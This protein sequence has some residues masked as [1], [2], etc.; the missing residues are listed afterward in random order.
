MVAAGWDRTAGLFEPEEFRDGEH[1][2]AAG[3][4][5]SVADAAGEQLA[6]WAAAFGGETLAA[7]RTF[8]DPGGGAG[9]AG[10]QRGQRCHDGV[11]LAYRHGPGPVVG[12]VTVTVVRSGTAGQLRPGFRGR[13]TGS[14]HG[15]RGGADPQCLTARLSPSPPQP[16]AL[17]RGVTPALRHPASAAAPRC[18]PAG[19]DAS[20]APR[21]ARRPTAIAGPPPDPPRHRCPR[22]R[23]AL[24]APPPGST[25][26]LAAANVS[27]PNAAAQTA[28]CSPAASAT[29]EAVPAAGR[30]SP[31][32]NYS[33]SNRPAELSHPAATIVTERSLRP[34][35]LHRRLDATI[36][37][38]FWLAEEPIRTVGGWLDMSERWPVVELAEPLTPALRQV[39][40]TEQ[41]D[42]SQNVTYVLADDDVQPDTVTVHGM[43]RNGPRRMTLIDAST[44]GRQ[45]VLGGSVGDPGMER[46]QADYAVL[47]GHIAGRGV[48]FTHARVQLQHLDVWAQLPGIEMQVATDGS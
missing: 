16:P 37:G 6:V 3:T 42:G 25:N 28:S 2:P 19:P 35:H 26:V 48:R 41:R 13:V 11:T 1:L 32:R 27:P 22:C 44:A 31:S 29:E 24:P 5:S 17:A 18:A 36:S 8:V 21:A 40:R 4:A 7:A 15:N 9:S 45:Q 39:A 12:A 46:L 20:V 47:G 30:C 33:G 34:G 43:L 23:P 38:R 10:R 14:G